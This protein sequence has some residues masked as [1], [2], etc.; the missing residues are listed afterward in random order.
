MNIQESKHESQ[1]PGIEGDMTQPDDGAIR[2][3]NKD[4][5]S[6]KAGASKRDAA[7]CICD[8]KTYLLRRVLSGGKV[9]I[10]ALVLLIPL[11]LWPLV[12]RNMVVTPGLYARAVTMVS[13]YLIGGFL[14]GFVLG[15][16]HAEK[17]DMRKAAP[18]SLLCLL[19][20]GI[21]LT[22][23]LVIINF[24]ILSS[25]NQFGPELERA[26][27]YPVFICVFAGAGFGGWAWLWVLRKKGRHHRL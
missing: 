20:L 14:G 26:G 19:I 22:V 9:A 10:V 15:P 6:V 21:G 17:A 5:N 4:K 24:L 27:W 7:E 23:I 18:I 1:D 2:N 16:G 3:E 25:S 12:D 11:L 13:W 8:V